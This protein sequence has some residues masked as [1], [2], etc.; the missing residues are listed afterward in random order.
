MRYMEHERSCLA[1]FPE[2]AVENSERSRVFLTNFKVFV[3]GVKQQ[4]QI[5][6]HHHSHYFLCLNLMLV[7]HPC[8]PVKLCS[9]AKTPNVLFFSVD[10]TF[11]HIVCNL[12]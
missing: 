1:T 4:D 3:N 6:K 9:I 10:L 12:Q 2:K 11:T 7:F 8:T 5:S